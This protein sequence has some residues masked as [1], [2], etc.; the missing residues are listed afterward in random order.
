MIKPDSNGD[1]CITPVVQSNI[2]AYL[3]AF[4]AANGDSDVPPVTYKKG[5]Y[6][7]RNTKM[8]QSE[9]LQATA[10]LEHRAAEIAHEKANPS[11]KKVV[12]RWTAVYETVITV[13]IDADPYGTT[14]KDLAAKIPIEVDGSE[15][16]SDTWEVESINPLTKE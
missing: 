9:F 13:P 7:V 10:R 11:T 5:W 14:V 16:Q 2:D 3:K 12:V 6:S 4:A 15:Y 8:R 1:I